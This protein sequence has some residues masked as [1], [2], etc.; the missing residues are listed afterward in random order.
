MLSLYYI[1]QNKTINQRNRARKK[2][3]ESNIN[4]LKCFFWSSPLSIYKYWQVTVTFMKTQTRYGHLYCA[5]TPILPKKGTI[6]LLYWYTGHWHFEFHRFVCFQGG[7]LNPSDF[8]KRD[9][10]LSIVWRPINGFPL[11]MLSYII[12]AFIWTR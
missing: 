11:L 5:H 12:N 7:C 9:N 4:L 1:Y 8:R 3:R 10:C 6:L 2:N